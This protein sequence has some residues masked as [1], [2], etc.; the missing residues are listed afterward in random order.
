MYQTEAQ[1]PETYRYEGTVAQARE[2][3][4]VTT[5]LQ[6]A[7]SQ[8]RDSAAGAT[9][10][11]L[12]TLDQVARKKRGVEDTMALLMRE[13]H[14][15]RQKRI[16]RILGTIALV[17]VVIGLV[18][19]HIQAG[20]FGW[21]LFKLFGALW[22]ADKAVGVRRNA[23]RTL[24]EAGDPR[25]VGVL[26]IAQ[27]DGDALVRRGAEEALLKLLPRVRAGD[28]AYITE[29][30]MQALLS[31]L[32]TGNDP[33]R[34]ALLRALEQIG[35]ERAIPYVNSLIVFGSPPVRRQAEQCQPYLE[36]R[37]RR[38]RESATLLRASSA[39]AVITDPNHLLRPSYPSAPQTPKEHLLRPVQPQ[40]GD[41]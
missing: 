13:I 20:G 23:A 25:A 17:I 24:G 12:A 37:A 16:R 35:D 40:P 15:A 36:E 8:L 31:L 21:M 41:G 18:T 33:L 22:V 2:D 9:Q 3:P 29:K 38:A 11:L 34:I 7:D 30:P 14:A 10:S 26:A 32:E 4:P 19:L 27:R 39:A 6:S 5:A 28:A 1:E